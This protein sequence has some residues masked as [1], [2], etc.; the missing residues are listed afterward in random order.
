MG[1]VVANMS[2]SLDGYVADPT[3]EV[4]E[5]FDWYGNGPVAVDMPGDH[6]ARHTRMSQASADHLQGKLASMGA[7]VAGR[8]LFDVAEGWGGA[9]PA[10]VPVVVVTHRAPEDWPHPQAPFSF[11]TDGVPSAIERARTLAGDKDVAVA[12]PDIIQQCLNAGLLDEISIDLVPVLFG[13]GI[14]FFG[15]LLDGHVALGD[16]VVVQGRRV[17]HLTY[18]V[19]RPPTAP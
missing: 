7:L 18:P 19:R 12:S 4:G 14:R 5:L 3:G 15:E 9:H 11:V 1:K 17:T 8:R 16:P 6:P 10:G 13:S 2:M